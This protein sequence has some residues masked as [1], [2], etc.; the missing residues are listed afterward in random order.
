MG[1]FGRHS[2]EQR[3]NPV[4]DACN[5]LYFVLFIFITFGI[6]KHIAWTC[7]EHVVLWTKFGIY[8]LSRSQMYSDYKPDTS[9]DNEQLKIQL[10][11]EMMDCIHYVSAYGSNKKECSALIKQQTT[12]QNVFTV[13]YWFI[14]P[15]FI[16]RGMDFSMNV[17]LYVDFPACVF[18]AHTKRTLTTTTQHVSIFV[19]E[20]CGW[21]R[22]QFIII[23]STH[24]IM[25]DA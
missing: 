3:A 10:C 14:E 1:K 5:I 17:L 19:A 16:T 18:G 25:C 12:E 22:V 13:K 11:L 15:L 6:T 21:H 24:V 2:T 20:C 9:L 4:Q 8:P 23:Q 7:Y